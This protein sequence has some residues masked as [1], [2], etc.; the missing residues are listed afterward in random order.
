[1]CLKIVFNSMNKTGY[2]PQNI[3][4][5]LMMP[6]PPLAFYEQN[7]WPPPSED[8]HSSHYPY[9]MNRLVCSVKI[10]QEI[11]RLGRNY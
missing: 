9:V 8:P 1:M 7:R 3:L 5:N 4:L 2:S 6:P 10:F 11:R